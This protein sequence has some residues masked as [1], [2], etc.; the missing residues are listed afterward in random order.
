M[1]ITNTTVA[2]SNAAALLTGTT[3]GEGQA[4]VLLADVDWYMGG[5]SV[6][7]ANGILVPANTKVT[8]NLDPG[9]KVYGIL[10]SGTG[11]CRVLK[12]RG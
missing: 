5:P 6:T 2:L 4:V 3:S 11:T 8:I 10:A 12:T 1:P 7:T 9:D